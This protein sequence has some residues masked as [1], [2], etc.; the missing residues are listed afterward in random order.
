VR[1]VQFRCVLDDHD[2]ITGRQCGAYRIEERFPVLVPL[3]RWC[4]PVRAPWIVSSSVWVMV[5]AR[6]VPRGEE[7][8]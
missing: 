5:P 4:G 8:R 1:Q 7:P 2:P 3:I 6:R